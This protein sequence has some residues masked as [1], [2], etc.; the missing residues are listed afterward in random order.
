MS[1]TI[2][3]IREGQDPMLEIERARVLELLHQ[4]LPAV[5]IAEVGST[6]VPGAIGKQDVDVVVLTE[7]NQFDAICKILDQILVRNEEQL[8]SDCFRGYLAST[9]RDVSF[10]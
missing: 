6:A 9:V 2:F 3:R 4:V 8:S 7:A 5:E 1:D 10:K